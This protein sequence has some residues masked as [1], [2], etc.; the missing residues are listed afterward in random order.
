MYADRKDRYMTK[1]FRRINL[2][3]AY[4]IRNSNEN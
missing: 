4:K 1:V 2:K 3:E